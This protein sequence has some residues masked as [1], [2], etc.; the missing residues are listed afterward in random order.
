MLLILLS[1]DNHRIYFNDFKCIIL[2]HGVLYNVII[3]L[4]K[5]YITSINLYL[6]MKIDDGNF[7]IIA[8]LKKNMYVMDFKCIILGHSVLYNVIINSYKVYI[9][10][11]TLYLKMKK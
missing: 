4:Y 5:V 8:I 1:D 9:T 6:K 3:N 7:R 11:I 2:G 10:S